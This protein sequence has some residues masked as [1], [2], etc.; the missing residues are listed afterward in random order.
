MRS[1]T[2][3]MGTPERIQALGLPSRGALEPSVATGADSEGAD[4]AR[5]G[6]P[7]VRRR[8]RWL[9]QFDRIAFGIVYPRETPDLGR[10][11]FRV[12]D[13]RDPAGVQLIEQAVEVADAQV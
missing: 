3:A 7:S 5:R 13:P 6:R 9:P 10:V 11:P 2:P 4:I 1:N 12:D 8:G